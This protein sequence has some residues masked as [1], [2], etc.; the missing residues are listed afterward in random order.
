MTYFRKSSSHSRYGLTEIIL[1]T[2]FPS[3]LSLFIQFYTFRVLYSIEATEILSKLFLGLISQQSCPYGF[4]GNKHQAVLE[5]IKSLSGFILES[6]QGEKSVQY[7]KLQYQYKASEISQRLNAKAIP[8]ECLSNPLNICV[9]YCF[10]G[11][12][13]KPSIQTHFGWN[14]MQGTLIVMRLIY[15]QIK[16]HRTFLKLKNVFE[17]NV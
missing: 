5:T 6:Q 4:K 16:L 15:C 17:N 12:V 3:P 14:L 8:P 10:N 7:L 13:Y 2:C 9:H 11:H 1:Q